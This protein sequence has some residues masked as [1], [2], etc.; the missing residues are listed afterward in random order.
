[1]AVSGYYIRLLPFCSPALPL[2]PWNPAAFEK[3]GETFFRASRAPLQPL[4][5]ILTSARFT[6][7]RGNAAV[8]HKK[9]GPP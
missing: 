9:E 3:A 2:S 8:F 4:I 1:M 5:S 7:L 6:A